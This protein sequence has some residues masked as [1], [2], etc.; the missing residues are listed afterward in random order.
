MLETTDTM[1][2]GPGPEVSKLTHLIPVLGWH[3]SLAETKVMVL[4]PR[5]EFS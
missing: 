2:D 4:L 3:L 5:D 1:K